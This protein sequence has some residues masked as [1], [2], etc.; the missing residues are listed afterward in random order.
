M[1]PQMIHFVADLL[2][3][4]AAKEEEVLAAYAIEHPPTIG[5]M[6]EGLTAK[7]LRAALPE[8]LNLQVVSGFATAG[9]GKIS[10][11]L[12]CMIVRGHG[13]I[14]PNTSKH[15]WP[16]QDVLAVVTVKKTLYSAALVEAYENLRAVTEVF[17]VHMHARQSNSE[18]QDVTPVYAAFQEITGRE[19][20][21][22]EDVQQLEPPLQLLFNTLIA[23]FI[24]PVRVMLGYQGFAS[25]QNFRAAFSKLVG[26]RRG[27][28]GY[29]VLGLPQLCVS[30]GYSLVKMNGQPILTPL[31][32]H[33]WWPLVASSA[34]NPLRFLLALLWARI[35]NFV[36][37]PMPWD[38][39]ELGSSLNPF[40]RV[41]AVE[42]NGETGWHFNELLM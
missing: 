6:Y 4:L 27:L 13:E 42:V 29:G 7:L 23:E 33:G 8:A 38:T 37:Q 12:D 1:L 19:L 18:P 5:A 26:A 17:S 20:T 32:E 41:K 35:E 40:L 14:V 11:E 22:W 28:R 31:D 36:G 16:V 39:L 9:Q 3:A 30:H 10:P 25:E 15:K 2:Q 34:D 21:T 24:S